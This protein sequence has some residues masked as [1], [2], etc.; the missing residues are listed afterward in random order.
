MPESPAFN[1]LSKGEREI[2]SRLLRMQ[3][4]EQKKSPKP[5]TAKGEAQRRRRENERRQ[6]SIASDAD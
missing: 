2:M 5:G 6:L 3:P 4:E 1:G